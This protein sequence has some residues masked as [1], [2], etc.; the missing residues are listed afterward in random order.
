MLTLPIFAQVRIA[1]VIAEYRLAVFE[2]QHVYVHTASGFVI[3]RLGIKVAVL[4]YF[5][6]TLRIMYLIIIVP[7]A[8][9]LIFPRDRKSVV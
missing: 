1:V 2:Q 7:S 4:P 5:A 8:I 6:A 3:N 9:L